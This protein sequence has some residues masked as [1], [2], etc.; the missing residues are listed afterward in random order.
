MEISFS[1]RQSAHCETGV[2]SNLLCHHGLNVSEPMVFGIGSGIF[3]GYFPFIRLNHL[4]LS[5]FRVRT[6]GIM[7][8]AVKRLGVS[9]V[10]EKFRDPGK[11]MKVL[12]RKLAESV[13]VGCRTGA[14]WLSYFPRRY[15]FHFNMH[16]LVV[17]GRQNGSYLISDPVF[18]EPVLCPHEDLMK[19]RFARG[20]MPPKGRMYYMKH[21]PSQPDLPGAVR[22]GIKE[23][24]RTML[25]APGPFLG[26]KGIRYLAKNVERWPEK[27]DAREAGLRLGQVIRMQEEI[28][29]GGGG[30][31]FIYAAFLQEA[32]GLL[33]DDR[34]G[35]LS[36]RMTE[37]GDLWREFALIGSRICKQRSAETET[38]PALA[39]ILRECADKEAR[40]YQDLLACMDPPPESAA[41]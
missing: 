17:F 25:K 24:C 33:N 5:A 29:T 3:F 9:L 4:P 28:G 30:F 27:L 31:R 8:R 19:A 22:Q 6:G 39:A 18:P 32:A 10:W 36:E 41:A 12:D 16:N 37:V 40:L 38:Y 15:R 34:L 35:R 7:K 11:A 1:H 13:P 20:P 2:L 14:Y 23:A 26:V 21:V